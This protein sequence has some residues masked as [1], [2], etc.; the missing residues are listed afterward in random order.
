LAQGKPNNPSERNKINQSKIEPRM[1]GCTCIFS[2]Q[3]PKKKYPHLKYWRR[4][5][6]NNCRIHNHTYNDYSFDS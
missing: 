6:V 5:I 4:S 1:K 3:A 2:L